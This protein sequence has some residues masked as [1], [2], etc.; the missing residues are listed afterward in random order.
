MPARFALLGEKTLAANV[1]PKDGMNS[2]ASKECST[3]VGEEYVRIKRGTHMRYRRLGRTELQVSEVG[4]GCEWLE[5]RTDAEVREIAQLCAD[6]GVNIMDCWVS[7]PVWRSKLG[8]ALAATG[9]EWHIQGHIGSTWDGS[10][11][12]RTREVEPC[13]RALDDLLT[14]FH[15]DHISFGMIHYVD[16]VAEMQSILAGGPYLDYMLSLRD[17]GVIKHIGYSTHN[18]ETGLMAIE[19]GIVDMILFSVNPAYDMKP[20]GEDVYELFGDYGDELQGMDPVRLEF[21]RAA[22]RADVGLTVMKTFAGGRLLDSD[23]SPFGVALTPHQC[24]HYALTRPAV[25][26]V[27][28]G[29]ANLDEARDCLAYENAPAE[30]LDYASVLAS[31][32]AHPIS[33]LCTYCGHCAPCTVGINIASV[34]K[35]YDLAEVQVA[36]TGEVPALVADH[37]AALEVHADECIACG[38]CEPRCPFGVEIVARMDAAAA[39]FG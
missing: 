7:D 24:M 22:E 13:K 26:S 36:A 20:A 33:G 3:I 29:F 27:L 38:A 28:T 10:Q 35:F 39:L 32:P 21:Y 16:S 2:S 18:P 25:A 15:T 19:S 30:E 12:V 4:L 9:T 5:N 31:A 23:R 17:Q 14:R 11:Y 6:A 37:Y 1:I 8:D 34:N